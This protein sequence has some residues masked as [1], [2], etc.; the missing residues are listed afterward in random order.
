MDRE[1]QKRKDLMG[2]YF[3]LVLM[4]HAD[5]SNTKFDTG[6]EPIEYT[7]DNFPKVFYRSQDFLVAVFFTNKKD[8]KAVTGDSWI[9]LANSNPFLQKYDT[10]PE[11]LKTLK[12]IINNLRTPYLGDKLRIS[13]DINSGVSMRLRTNL[14]NQLEEIL[15]SGKNIWPNVV[16]K[17]TIAMFNF[18]N[19]YGEPEIGNSIISDD[20]TVELKKLVGLLNTDPSWR[21]FSPYSIT[22]FFLMHSTN[23]KGDERI[24]EAYLA[25][26][27]GE[28]K[29]MWQ[30]GGGACWGAALRGR[31][32]RKRYR[33]K[34]MRKHNYRR[35]K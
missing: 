18:Y 34:K 26:G 8:M 13:D 30:G 22:G 15:K 9:D 17:L 35:S 24:R 6:L 20:E 29:G 19:L 1:Q 3:L 25:S 21:L 14:A 7:S 32:G 4:T 16:L 31:G 11:F 10:N 5:S 2:L 27:E 12:N 33:S 28:E 23:E